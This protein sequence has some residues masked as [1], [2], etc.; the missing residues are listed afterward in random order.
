M[1]GLNDERWQPSDAELRLRAK[2]QIWQ[3]N[4]DARLQQRLEAQAVKQQ[5]TTEEI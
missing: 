5:P 2:L 3:R 1:N 4:L